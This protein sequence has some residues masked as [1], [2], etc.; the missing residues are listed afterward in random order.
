MS[1]RF[2][3]LEQIF[4]ASLALPEGQRVAYLAARKGWHQ[5]SEP[6]PES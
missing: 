5:L 1:N 6:D 3:L 4:D 2:K